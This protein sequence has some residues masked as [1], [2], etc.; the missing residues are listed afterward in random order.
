MHHIEYEIYIMM[1]V[2]KVLTGHIN[3]IEFEKDYLDPIVDFE[4]H[5]I[6]SELVDE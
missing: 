1:V 3:E 2:I 6:P 5:K 4:P